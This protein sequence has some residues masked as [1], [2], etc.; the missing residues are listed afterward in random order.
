[1]G[2]RR[3]ATDK[4]RDRLES[5]LSSIEQAIRLIDDRSNLPPGAEVSV[6]VLLAH[7]TRLKAK[8]ARFDEKHGVT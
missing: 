8:I 2:A 1:M 4:A 3:D 6:V 5:D 7:R